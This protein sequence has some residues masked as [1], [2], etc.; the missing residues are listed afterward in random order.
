MNGLNGLNEFVLKLTGLTQH[1][2][3]AMHILGYTESQPIWLLT[4]I[5]PNNGPHILV[6]AGFHGDEPAGPWGIL[7]FLES[8]TPT[9]SARANLSFLPIVNPTGFQAARHVNDRGEDP[10]RGFCHVPFNGFVPSREGTILL[11][12][13][14]ELRPL[15]TDGFVSLHEDI[16]QER[17][18]LYTFEDSN[19]PGPFSEVLRT[20]GT[21]YFMTMPDGIVEGS[22]NRGGVIF[23]QCDGSFEDCLFHAGVPRTACTETPGL[24]NI[25]ERIKTNANIIN[26]FLTFTIGACS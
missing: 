15:A 24:Q 10:N 26:A 16:E 2:G 12:Q 6:A 14:H 1:C 22:P 20:A 17:F 11:E 23:R 9:I 3:L 5:Y 21:E 13:L 8:S 4:P 19:G 25:H 7:H 18:Y